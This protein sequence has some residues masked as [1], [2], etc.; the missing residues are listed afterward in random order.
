MKHDKIEFF[1][2]LDWPFGVHG[3]YLASDMIEKL[4]DSAI[5]NILME[6]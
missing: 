6:L 3:D 4:M 1:K 2:V 5:D